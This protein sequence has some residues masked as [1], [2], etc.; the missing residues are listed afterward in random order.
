MSSPF[1]CPI[2]IT[3]RPSMRARP[4][5]IAGSSANARSPA[6]RQE[7][8]GQAGDIMVE[9]RPVRDAA[10]P[11]SSATGSA[12]HRCRGAASRPWPRA[13]R[14]RHRYRPRPPPR[15]R[16][17][18]RSGSR[19]RRSAFRN[20]DRS[21]LRRSVGR[22]WRRGQSA[23]GERMARIDQLDQPGAVDMGVDLRRRDIGMAEQRL[24]HAQVRPARQ[25][26]GGEGMAQDVRT[27]PVG[28][29]SGVARRARGRSGTAAPGS[30]ASCRSGTATGLSLATCSP[31]LATAA[32]ARVEIGTSRSLSPLPR[33]I[34]NGWPA[35]TAR[36]GSDTSSLA[37]SPDP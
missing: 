22:C 28:R 27:D 24:Q 7:I 10:R 36:R 37:R 13:W 5:M 15:S 34:R 12:S 2:S 19:A 11:A 9:V 4:P 21:H 33:R 32:S 18:R 14:S 25:Q 6:K 8:V 29:N 30:G 16:A 26:M 1:S 35:R 17:V 23:V 20:R 31:T 3:W